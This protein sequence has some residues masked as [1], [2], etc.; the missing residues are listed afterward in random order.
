MPFVFVVILIHIE[1]EYFQKGMAREG[2]DCHMWGAL[3]YPTQLSDHSREH[4]N[5]HLPGDSSAST[6]A[7]LL[8]R[9]HAPRLLIMKTVTFIV[10]IRDQ[11]RLYVNG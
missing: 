4:V 7:S 11:G 9:R 8:I 10:G 5:Y 6:H 1:L 3:D 2:V